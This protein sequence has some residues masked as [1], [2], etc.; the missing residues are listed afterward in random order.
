MTLTN[1]TPSAWLTPDIPIFAPRTDAERAAD[2]YDRDFAVADLYTGLAYGHLLFEEGAAEGLY[3]T[4]SAL[5]LSRRPAPT[6]ILDIGCGVARLPFDCAPV[7]PNAQFTALD[8]SYNMCLRAAQIVRATDPVPLPF[9]ARRGRP[10]VVFSHA[11]DLSNVTILQASAEGLP[12]PPM[13]F[14]AVTGTLV[15]CRLNDPLRGLA[16]MVRVLRPGGSLLLATPLGFRDSLHWDTF[17]DAARM[18]QLLSS[19]GLRIDE[20]FDGLRYREVIDAHG[21]AQEWNVR[22]IAASL[23]L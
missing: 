22:V 6:N 4:I 12:F 5:L 9:W 16:E 2:P 11:R 8:Y 23:L 10:N 13:S 1:R 21:N 19:L 15:L 3:R 14:D 18:R 20:C 7:M 17:A